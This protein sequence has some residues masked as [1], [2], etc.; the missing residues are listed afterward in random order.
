MTVRQATQEEL[1]DIF[2]MGYDTWGKEKSPDD[3]LQTCHNSEKYQQGTWCVL[4]AEQQIVSSLIIYEQAFG[5][6]ANTLGIGSVATIPGHRNKGYAAALVKGVT[7]MAKSHGAEAIYLFSDIDP[8]F[9]K[10][11]GFSETVHQSCDSCCMLLT[12]TDNDQLA[13][14]EL[15]YF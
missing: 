1:N 5:L 2:M 14:A 10:K 12:F 3:Y 13:Q 11:L 9:Y 4:E 8:A 15:S 7:E 6:P